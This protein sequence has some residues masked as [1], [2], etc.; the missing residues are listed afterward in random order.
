MPQQKPII[1]PGELFVEDLEAIVNAIPVPGVGITISSG[2]VW[3]ATGESGTVIVTGWTGGGATG[4]TGNALG[5][6][7]FYPTIIQDGNEFLVKDETVSMLNR[8]TGLIG[9]NRWVK[10]YLNGDDYI[11][12]W[13][14]CNTSTKPPLLPPPNP[15]EP[16]DPG[17]TDEP[18]LPEPD[19][20]EGSTPVIPT[21]EGFGVEAY[22]IS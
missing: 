9:A 13:T 20:P 19:P 12:F 15:P 16:P 17:D 2:G 7:S 21:L 14:D 18:V 22:G 8:S 10:C 6:G 11:N 5:A 4:R 3:N 1:K